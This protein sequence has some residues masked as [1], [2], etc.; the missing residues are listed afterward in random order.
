MYKR[1]L[2]I[3]LISFCMLIIPGCWD[4]IEIERNA[5]ILGLGIDLSDDQLLITY[6]IALLDAFKG[7]GGEQSKS[8]Q[9]I[10]IV[11][12]SLSEATKDLL[13][14][15]GN[16][17]NFSHCKLIVFGEKYAKKGI[18]DSLDFLFR[19]TDMRRV[20]SVCVADGEAKEIL[21]IEPKTAPSSAIV[22]DQI[23]TQNSLSNSDIF[24]FQDI[25]YIHH[26]FVRGSDIGLAK[27]SV[28]KGIVKVSGAGLFK[29]YKLIGWYTDHEVTG[30]RFIL[31]ELKEGYHS[32]HLPWDEG[33][34]ITMNAYNINAST[35]PKITDGNIV[36]KSRIL[37]EG[38]ITE[39]GNPVLV[40]T[41]E[42][43]IKYWQKAIEDDIRSTINSVYKK[44]RDIYG[45]DAFEFDQKIESYYPE[46]WKKNKDNWDE[47]FKTVEL[48]LE[49]DVKLRRLGIIEP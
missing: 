19:E 17:P 20:T 42:R 22:I 46:F 2:L 30:L 49:I 9:Q 4:R 32:V 16:M 25:G 41:S 12:D 33:D 44:G 45:V 15:F 28:D 40:N 1:I 31:G 14:F 37:I 38:D 48:D 47:L 6:Q 27:V 26:N 10:S 39:I 23:I 21:N 43:L 5:F 18:S 35:I 11:A 13:S 7:E 3:C 8:T 34:R 29:D 24:P 36:V